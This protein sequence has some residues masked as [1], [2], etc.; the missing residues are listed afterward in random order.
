MTNKTASPDAGGLLDL[1]YAYYG[2]RA[3]STSSA[4]GLI[5]DQNYRTSYF[6][7]AGDRRRDMI[8][9]GHVLSRLSRLPASYYTLLHHQTGRRASV[10]WQLIHNEYT[11]VYPEYS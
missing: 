6:T 2:I 9:L 1:L 8:V 4:L 11:G 7:P 3:F 5:R 10:L